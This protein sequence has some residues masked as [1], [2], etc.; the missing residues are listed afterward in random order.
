VLSGTPIL[1]AEDQIFIALDLALAIEDA[2]GEV[3]GPA[4]SI[5]EALYLLATMTIAAAIL[6]F[7]LVDGDCS[8]VVEVLANRHIPTIIQTG[9]ELPLGLNVR[10]PDLVVHSKPCATSKLVGQL[11]AMI[12]HRRACRA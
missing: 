4:A 3:I 2:G 6:D 11:E 1:V 5:A 12:D 9:A 8:A 10:F 7:E